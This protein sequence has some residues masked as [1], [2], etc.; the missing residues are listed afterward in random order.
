[1]ASP[2][3]RGLIEGPGYGPSTPHRLSTA[4]RGVLPADPGRTLTGPA[5]TGGAAVCGPAPGWSVGSLMPLAAPATWVDV[6]CQRLDLGHESTDASRHIPLRILVVDDYPTF[7]AGLRAMLAALPD[8]EVIGEA[9]TGGQAVKAV[10]EGKPEVVV[11]G[12]G[13]PDMCGIEATRRIVA[14]HPSVG[15]LVLT[16]LDDDNTAVLGLL[17][18]GVRGCLARSADGAEIRRA[19]EAVASGA[20]I[21]GAAIVRRVLA[22]FAGDPLAGSPKPFPELTAREREVLELIAAGECNTSIAH[23]LVL[24]PKT[25]RNHI[26]SIF[27][28]L[29]IPDRS[30]AIV[31]ARRAGLGLG[32][33]RR[34]PREPYEVPGRVGTVL[35]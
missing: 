21:F 28:K 3:G 20:A 4:R 32:P 22:L 34:Y 10:A 29:Q 33:P 31:R 23:L 17:R 11:L 24:S 27:A 1:M 19:I 2:P 13:L 5:P 7:R 25:V 30:Q 8:T 18:E 16:T 14:A 26:S 9:A 12:L 15:I 35:P 6:P